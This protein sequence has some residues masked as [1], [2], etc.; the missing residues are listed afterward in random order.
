MTGIRIPPSPPQ[1]DGN[2]P[3]L[4]YQDRRRLRRAGYR[5]RR[6][7]PGALGRLVALELTTYADLGCALT[8]D[9]LIRALTEEIL[10]ADPDGQ[11]THTT[12][13]WPGLTTALTPT[14]TRPAAVPS[15]PTGET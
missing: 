13:S 10:A 8:P 14:P 12:A 15:A 4:D 6:L 1:P 5:A 2:A 3:R 7:Y 11:K 9:G